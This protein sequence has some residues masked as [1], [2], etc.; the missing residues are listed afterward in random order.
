MKKYLLFNKI[1][2]YQKENDSKILEELIMQFS[3]LLKK[4]ASKISFEDSMQDLTVTFIEIMLKLPLDKVNEDKYILAYISTSIKNKYLSLSSDQYKNSI[5]DYQPKD[6]LENIIK[7]FNYD[8]I[9]KFELLNSMD[10]LTNKEKFI[11]NSIFFKDI[12]VIDISKKLNESRQSVNQ[13][14]LKALKKLKKELL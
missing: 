13:V 2:K 10:S 5:I 12:S 8:D 1:Y 4:Y 6:L 14:K 11:I 3:P 7:D 9:S